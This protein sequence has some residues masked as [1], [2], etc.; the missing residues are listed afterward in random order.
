LIELLWWDGCPSHP[1]A[2][3]DLRAV[4]AEMGV[5]PDVVV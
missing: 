3:A 1:A 2:L 5:D 4:L